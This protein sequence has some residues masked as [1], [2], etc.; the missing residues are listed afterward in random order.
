MERRYRALRT[1]AAVYKILGIIVA[2]LTVLSVLAICVTMALGGAA[3]SS[4]SDQVPLGGMMGGALGGA[5]VGILGIIYGGLISLSLYG[6]G[7]MVM[8]LI[9]IEEN[10]RGAWAAAAARPQGAQV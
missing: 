8:L 3:S 1:I 2:V 6:F 9:A 7:E 4:L 5:F 10:T